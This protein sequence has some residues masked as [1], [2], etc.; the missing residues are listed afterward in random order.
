MRTININEQDK[1]FSYEKGYK[2]RSKTLYYHSHK[3][4]DEDGFSAWTAEAVGTPVLPGLKQAGIADYRYRSIGGVEQ[5]AG[6]GK[7]L[8]AFQMQSGNLPSVG[9]SVSL[10]DIYYGLFYEL[11]K[12]VEIGRRDGFITVEVE[13]PNPYIVSAFAQLVFYHPS[14]LATPNL[15]VPVPMELAIEPRAAG[16]A[17]GVTACPVSV[18][19]R[20]AATGRGN[21]YFSDQVASLDVGDAVTLGPGYY[22]FVACP[23]P[24]S[25]EVTREDETYTHYVNEAPAPFEVRFPAKERVFYSINGGYHCAAEPQ[26]DSRYIQPGKT[27]LLFEGSPV[28]L[29][30]GEEIA[31]AFNLVGTDDGNEVVVAWDAVHS[32]GDGGYFNSVRVARCSGASAQL[33]Y[34]DRNPD[35]YMEKP[36]YRVG[37][38][39]LAAKD[40]IY[41]I[42]EL[43]ERRWIDTDIQIVWAAPPDAE[44]LP[45]DYDGGRAVIVLV[46]GDQTDLLRQG[47]LI[48]LRPEIGGEANGKDYVISEAGTRALH[49]NDNDPNAL[50]DEWRDREEV[51]THLA[52]LHLDYSELSYEEQVRFE[53]L[54]KYITAAGGLER[55]SEI[56]SL[57]R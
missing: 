23:E 32:D 14:V 57:E 36:A 4:L 45:D 35:D 42:R 39:L 44:H 38:G 11:G 54:G 43:C 41:G 2:V 9:W 48:R 53:V 29:P 13:R 46:A 55:R 7:R 27:R 25:Y 5:G 26:D 18:Q 33:L 24:Q 28:L 22:A 34:E 56:W 1:F 47:C 52:L 37:G 49:I 21:C 10:R 12:A 30:G 51:F 3:S 20:E 17:P 16:N 31:S 19:R 8:W 40:R 50:N 6:I 15:F